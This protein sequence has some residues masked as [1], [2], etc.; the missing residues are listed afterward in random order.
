MEQKG[1]TNQQQLSILVPLYEDILGSLL[2]M[3]KS[4][5]DEYD[6]LIAKFQYLRAVSQVEKEVKE[7]YYKA[8]RYKRNTL[9]FLGDRSRET[10][11]GLWEIIKG[12]MNED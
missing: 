5:R 6:E 4:Q 2:D 3:L 10:A 7:K 8:E 1:Y 12:C 11:D 9:R